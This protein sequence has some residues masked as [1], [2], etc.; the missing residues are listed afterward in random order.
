MR[1][2]QPEQFNPER[3]YKP[4]ERAVI[5]DTVLVA[6]VWTAADARFANNNPTMFAQRCVRCKIKRDDCPGIGRQC[7]KY[8]RADRKTIYWRMLR[9]AGGFKS[10]ETLEFNYNGTIAGVKVEATPDSNNK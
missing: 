1:V 8:H 9:I 10:F 2:K 7:D 6:E 4:G 5:N 3:E